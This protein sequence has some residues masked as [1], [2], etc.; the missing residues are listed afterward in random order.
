MNAYRIRRATTDDLAQLVALW[1]SLGMPALE[2]EKTF[3]DF[4]IAEDPK[5][6]LVGAI[7]MR[8]E[9]CEGCIH[10]ESIPDFALSDILRPLFWERFALVARNHGLV[11]VWT[12]DV[13]PFWKKDA[14]FVEMPTARLRELPPAFGKPHPAWLLLQLR[15]EE[16]TPS[17]IEKQFEI[18][19]A[20]QEL[21]R[22][23]TLRQAKAWARQGKA[24]KTATTIFCVLIF[25]ASM[26]ALFYAMKP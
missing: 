15:D 8:I 22:L 26:V 13:A 7:A 1:Q 9:G 23:A 24:I 20:T 10:S 17:A 16:T 3:T 25:L 2:L 6:K 5:N 14:A 19:M 12:E 4:Q 21:E 18:I 11:R